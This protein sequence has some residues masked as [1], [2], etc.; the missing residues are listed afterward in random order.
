[1]LINTGILN[2]FKDALST[3]LTQS[4]SMKLLQIGNRIINPAQIL[5]ASYEP[6]AFHPASRDTWKE[7]VVS[8]AGDE[9][10]IFY[11]DEAETVW[12]FLSASMHCRNLS[13]RAEV[14]A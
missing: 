14:A 12:G 3:H 1:M 8:F 9:T 2:P 11:N 13:T 4:K 10:A 7:C 5:H 6:T